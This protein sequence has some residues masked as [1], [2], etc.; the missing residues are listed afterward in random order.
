MT[1]WA[2][3]GEGGG[4]RGQDDWNRPVYNIWKA[5]RLKWELESQQVDEMHRNVESEEI[6]MRPVLD[7]ASLTETDKPQLPPLS[8]VTAEQDMNKHFNVHEL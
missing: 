4:L 5:Q 1:V 6:N 3:R 8:P 7:V 2:A